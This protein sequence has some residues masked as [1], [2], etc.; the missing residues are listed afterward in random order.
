MSGIIVTYEIPENQVR[1][2]IQDEMRGIERGLNE[3]VDELLQMTAQAQALSYTATANP[4]PPS[5]S[6]YRRTFDLREASET[7]KLSSRL[8]VVSGEWIANE[9]KARYAKYVIGSLADQARIHQGRWKSLEEVTQ[10]INEK[11]PDVVKKHVG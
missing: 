11:A 8:P 7:Q 5:G 6:T 10:E 3:A 1:T 4:A 9:A 2:V